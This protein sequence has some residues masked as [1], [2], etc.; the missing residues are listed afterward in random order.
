MNINYSNFK[1]F[2]ISLQNTK[3]GFKRTSVDFFLKKNL[4]SWLHFMANLYYIFMTASH[5]I[6]MTVSKDKIV[7]YHHGGT[8]WQICII[9]PYVHQMT[10]LYIISIIASNCKIYNISMIASNGKFVLNFHD[11]I[12][13]QICIIFP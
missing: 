2:N 1:Y 9:F 4:F 12:K 13:W 10:K 11:C 7:S 6:Y 8:I 5:D 3:K